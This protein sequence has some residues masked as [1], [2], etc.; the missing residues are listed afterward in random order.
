VTIGSTGGSVTFNGRIDGA[1]HLTV[2]G[3]AQT[4]T[5]NGPGSE[6]IFTSR[7]DQSEVKVVVSGDAREITLPPLTAAVLK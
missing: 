4:V 6:V 1:E 2:S 7:G 5:F 3:G